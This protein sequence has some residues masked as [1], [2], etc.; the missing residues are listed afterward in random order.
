MPFGSPSY[1]RFD[2]EISKPKIYLCLHSYLARGND[3][4]PNQPQFQ[5][6][7]PPYPEEI[8]EEKLPSTPKTKRIG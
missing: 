4:T 2:I 5:R 8:E 1:L 6:R 7:I 3:G